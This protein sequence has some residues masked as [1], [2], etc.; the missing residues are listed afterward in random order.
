MMVF[1]RHWLLV[2][3]LLMAAAGWAQVPGRG[4]VQLSIASEDVGV[5]VPGYWFAASA[6]ASLSP[7]V[8]ALHGCDG[9]LDPKGRLGLLRL[10]YVQL[11]NDAGI[12]VLFIDSFSGRGEKSICSQ[13]PTARKITE[14]NR[15]L[16]VYGAL[17]WLAGQSGVDPARLG[18]VGWSHGGQTVLSSA[19]QTE[20]VVKNAMVR[21]AALVAFYPGC[22]KFEKMFRYEA[23]APLLVMSGELDDWTPA[24]PCKRLTDRLKTRAAG[25]PVEYLEMAGSYHAFDSSIAPRERLDVGGTR[26]GKATVGGNP[27]AREASAQAM[28]RFL[29]AQFRKVGE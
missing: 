17:K 26:S 19:D 22:T 3:G 1:V 4:P 8:V 29:T 25:S 6:G 13:K 28:I 11:L 24:A 7:A 18:V 14:E 10:R 9:L 15:R 12:G 20:D 5:Q 16:D 2:Y 21:P 27:A 23:V